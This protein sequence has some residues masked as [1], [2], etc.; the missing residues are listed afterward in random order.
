MCVESVYVSFWSYYSWIHVGGIL[1]FYAT[2][3]GFL[4]TSKNDCYPKT[5]FSLRRV[6]HVSFCLTLNTL[7]SI[8][9]IIFSQIWFNAT[10]SR[11]NI[12]GCSQSTRMRLLLHVV[13]LFHTHLHHASSLP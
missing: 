13:S 9:H 8:T 1:M 2:S 11:N 5:T 7:H 3:F 12:A 6:G 4:K 10:F